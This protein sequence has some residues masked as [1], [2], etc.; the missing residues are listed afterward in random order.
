M[1]ETDW[2][3]DMTMESVAKHSHTTIHGLKRLRPATS[4]PA[5]ASMGDPA[6]PDDWH[7]S[8]AGVQP[9]CFYAGIAADSFCQLRRFLSRS[10][11]A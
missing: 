7:A 1:I 9:N 2:R 11:S 3:A 5:P 4:L 8:M 10:A 6:M